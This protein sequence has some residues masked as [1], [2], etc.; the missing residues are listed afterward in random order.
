MCCVV[1]GQQHCTKD[2]KLVPPTDINF[3][4]LRNYTSMIC[5]FWYGFMK[6][7]WFFQQR[8][9]NGARTSGPMVC[10]TVYQSIL[11][12]FPRFDFLIPKILPY[13]VIFFLSCGI[14]PMI[15]PI[16]IFAKV[17]D[18]WQHFCWCCYGL[19]I[20]CKFLKIIINLLIFYCQTY[21][22]FLEACVRLMM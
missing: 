12:S 10:G 9:P 21:T 18:F 8:L 15:V 3:T 2:I 20:H 19:Y 1:C 6:T 22:M 7:A 17:S 13:V 14:T 5:N 11:H 16:S 4:L